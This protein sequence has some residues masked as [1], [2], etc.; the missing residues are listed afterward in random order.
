M[1]L[2][3]VTGMSGAG[4][5]KVINIFEDLGYY[6]IDNIPPILL[7]KFVEVCG[8]SGEN[9][10]KIAVVMDTRGGDLFSGIQR[11]FDELD[12]FGIDHKILF[13]DASDSELLRRYKETRRKHPLL[14]MMDG[15]VEDAIA[16]ER[17]MLDPIKEEADF[18]IDTTNFSSTKLRERIVNTFSVNEA[19][20]FIINCISFGFK[21][22][23]PIESDLVFD[24][25]CLPNPFYVE[26]LKAKTGLDK[27]VEDYVLKW[28]QAVELLE[29]LYDLFD[30]LLPL[31][32]AEGK[33]QLV[34]SVGCTGGKHRSVVFAEKIAEHLK[35]AGYRCITTHRDA[36]K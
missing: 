12:E 13:L 1:E 30:F 29:K 26:E 33:S 4:K 2:I 5:S 19:K 3:V 6:C 25:R 18:I 15:S 32:Q 36:E 11:A 24:V 22:G 27:D 7:P 21:Y 16:K 31:Y 9:T 28:P 10:K 23:L 14:D 34:I 17:E 35:N 20:S 8:Q